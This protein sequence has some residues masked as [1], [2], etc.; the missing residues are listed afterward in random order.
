M[1][2]PGDMID[3]LKRNSMPYEIIEHADTLNS[4]EAAAVPNN[5]E[6][7]HA[8]TL[9]VET[10]NKYCMV[11]VPADRY[12]D[13][14]LLLKTIKAEKLHLAQEEELKPLFPNYKSGTM[15][16]FGN[17]Y[18]LPIYIEKSLTDAEEI[19]F[20]AFSDTKS[21]RLKMDDYMKLAGPIVAEFS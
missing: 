6:R 13:N 17:L 12:M 7:I 9:V 4:Y 21:I 11:V 3:Y 2:K 10:G 1:A 14:N 19:T 18:A 15:P 20:N 8:K 16:P 5:P